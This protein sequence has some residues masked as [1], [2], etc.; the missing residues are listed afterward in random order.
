MQACFMYN[1]K[2]LYFLTCCNSCED[3][4]KVFN[5]NC[6]KKNEITDKRE[7]FFI[8]TYYEKELYIITGNRHSITYYI[9]DENRIYHKYFEANFRFTSY[10]NNN[11]CYKKFFIL[12]LLKNY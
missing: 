11:F 7:S 10:Y 12:L 1:N 4:I 9:Y 3:P 5:W 6:K 8:D 2:Q